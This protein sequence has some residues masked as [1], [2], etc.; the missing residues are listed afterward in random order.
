MKKRSANVVELVLVVISLVLIFVMK[1]DA[2]AEMIA[3]EGVASGTV[4]F[5]SVL[6]KETIY[7]IPFF[8]L[9]GINLLICVLG[10][11]SSKKDGVMHAILPIIL[12]AFSDFVILALMD[13]ANTFFILQGAMFA[14]IIVAFIKRSNKIV[15]NVQ[16][17]KIVNSNSTDAD[18]LKKYK[19]LLD[20]GAITQEEFDAKKK[21]L[22]GL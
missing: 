18:E 4:S 8:V 13:T 12:F 21:E 14:M 17:V 3:H 5:L 1:G 19:D 2:G 11:L 22:L 16:E 10:I 7:A 9:W 20:S 15:D 6:S